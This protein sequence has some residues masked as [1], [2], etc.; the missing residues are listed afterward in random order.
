MR[1]MREIDKE[2]I[3]K[4]R[5]MNNQTIPLLASLGNALY[6]MAQLCTN[7]ISMGLVP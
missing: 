4:A 2:T 1:N 5:K 3:R 7:G 6:G